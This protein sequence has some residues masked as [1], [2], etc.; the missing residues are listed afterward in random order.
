M[1]YS[2]STFKNQNKEETITDRQDNDCELINSNRYKK[3]LF[4]ENS[5]ERSIINY[6]IS[7]KH[8]CKTI[9]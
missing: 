5:K 9:T 4:D 3:A 7:K 2:S 1:S 8:W 6:N